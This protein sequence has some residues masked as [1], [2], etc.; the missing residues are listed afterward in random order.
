[1]GTVAKSP[2]GGQLSATRI[3]I[4]SDTTGVSC[5]PAGSASHAHGLSISLCNFT[6]GSR[7]TRPSLPSAGFFQPLGS[8]DR[9]ATQDVDLFITPLLGCGKSGMRL[10]YGGGFTIVFLRRY[11]AFAWA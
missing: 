2:H 8:A 1:M 6:D 11:R 10:G 3:R 5:D 9:V 7:V 4:R